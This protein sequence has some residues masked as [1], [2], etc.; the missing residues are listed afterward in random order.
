MKYKV[1]WENKLVCVDYC[2]EIE[3]KDIEDAHFELNGDERFY[4]CNYL[5]LNITNCNL[6]KVSVPGRELLHGLCT[7]EERFCQN[8]SS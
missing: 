2:G 5:I 6:D 3:I 4:D 1:T 8:T 7:C